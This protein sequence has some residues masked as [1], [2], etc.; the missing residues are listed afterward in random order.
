MSRRRALNHKFEIIAVTSL[1]F[2]LVS[3]T[4]AFVGGKANIAQGSRSERLKISAAGFGIV[5]QNESQILLGLLPTAMR[6]TQQTLNE[7]NAM[8]AKALKVHAK[9]TSMEVIAVTSSKNQGQ[10]LSTVI[11]QADDQ[12]VAGCL[13][14]P[15]L[16]FEEIATLGTSIF[17]LRDYSP[18]SKT[19]SGNEVQ[20]RTLGNACS[21]TTEELFLRLYDQGLISMA[22][23]A[24][25]EEAFEMLQHARALAWTLHQ[26]EPTLNPQGHV[27]LP[28]S[29]SLLYEWAIVRLLWR[30]KENGRLPMKELTPS[31][32]AAFLALPDFMKLG[33]HAT[34]LP[35]EITLSAESCMPNPDAIA[36]ALGTVTEASRVAA[37]RNVGLECGPDDNGSEY[38]LYNWSDEPAVKDLNQSCCAKECELLMLTTRGNSGL[39]TCCRACNRA[40]M[41][42]SVKDNGAH[43]FDEA[44]EF[45]DLS[46]VAKPGSM[47]MKPAFVS[48]VI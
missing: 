30:L 12:A 2:A 25:R 43:E 31:E 15:R 23:G 8:L 27:S 20:Y 36:M 7:A 14:I 11:D 42:S 1:V 34:E 45:A 26:C 29:Y 28:S 33:K 6:F 37:T 35:L 17:S 21:Q 9:A 24:T 4:Q 32:A 18:K 39:D 3:I 41:C 47:S 13:G 10:L 19:C 22:F 40:N 44:Q 5:K 46:T 38:F 48:M 16:S